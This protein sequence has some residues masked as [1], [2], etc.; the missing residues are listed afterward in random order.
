MN[1][2]MIISLYSLERFGCNLLLRLHLSDA[3]YYHETTFCASSPLGWGLKTGMQFIENCVLLSMF[4]EL[5]Y[6]TLPDPMPAHTMP[7]P[8]MTYQ[9]LTHLLT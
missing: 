9:N 8:C 6:L 7:L 3:P 5:T 4:V 1:G 2:H